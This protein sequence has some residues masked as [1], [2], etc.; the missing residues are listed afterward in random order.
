[1]VTLVHN[2]NLGEALGKET[3]DILSN[4]EPR[5]ILELRSNRAEGPEREKILQS[6]S[7]QTSTSTST[8]QKPITA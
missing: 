1:M 3:N 6:K 8:I 7:L 2:K 4:E 5:K